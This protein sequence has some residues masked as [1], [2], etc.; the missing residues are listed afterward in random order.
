MYMYIVTYRCLFLS[1]WFLQRLG[2][3]IGSLLGLGVSPYLPFLGGREMCRAEWP[4]VRGSVVL[5]G[6]F[7]PWRT[8]LVR[9][10]H[11]GYLGFFLEGYEL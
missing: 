6:L 5:L 3:F 2:G 1:H 10:L 11:R 4:L 8:F 9:E 7:Q